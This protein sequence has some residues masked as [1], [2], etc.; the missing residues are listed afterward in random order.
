LIE[1]GASSRIEFQAKVICDDG[2][3]DEIIRSTSRGAALVLLGFQTPD[4]GEEL[5][6]FRRM[7]QIAGDLPRVLLVDSAGGMELES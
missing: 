4:E 6:L 1:L 5:E 7:E 2:S 3:P